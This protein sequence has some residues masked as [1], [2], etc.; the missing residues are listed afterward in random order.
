MYLHIRRKP[1]TYAVVN[2]SSVNTETSVET[3]VV[4]VES[5]TSVFVVVVPATAVVV[6]VDVGCVILWDTV[7]VSNASFQTWAMVK[8]T[9]GAR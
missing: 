4:V 3:T 9:L 6:I 1:F 7:S 2:F 8:P 5:T